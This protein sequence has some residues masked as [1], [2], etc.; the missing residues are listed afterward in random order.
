MT[1]GILSFLQ[2]D[3]ELHERD[4]YNAFD[5]TRGY[6]DVT[7]RLSD[8]VKVRFTTNV[9]PTTDASL[10]A[11][12]TARLEYAY[13]EAAWT[14]NRTFMFGMQPD[15]VAH[16]RGIDRPLSRARADVRRARGLDSRPERSRRGHQ[17]TSE[18]ASRCTV[19]STTARATAA[20]RS[21]SSRACRAAATVTVFSTDSE[22]A[23]VRHLG[24][25]LSTAGTRRIVRA[26]SAS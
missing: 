12:L 1:F 23:K 18:R 25:L 10:D 19:A 11:N 7:G 16:L 14:P 13:L 26:T 5:V 9:R 15:A 3:Y 22:P 24:V 20:P 2:Y 4:G 21:T 8:R 6:L 17:S